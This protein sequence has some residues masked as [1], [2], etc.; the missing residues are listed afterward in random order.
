MRS[1]RS[2]SWQRHELDFGAGEIAVGRDQAHQLDGRGQDEGRRILDVAGQR[3]VDGAGGGGLALETDPA[4][5]VRLRVHVDEEDAL[6]VGDGER[7]RQVDGG[8]GFT[9]ATLLVG[10]GEDAG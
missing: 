4:G 8:G 7:G 6:L 3:V 9:D 1:R 2:R 5:Q 10:D